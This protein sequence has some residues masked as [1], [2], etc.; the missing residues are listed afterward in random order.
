MRKSLKQYDSGEDMPLKSV[1]TSLRRRKSLMCLL[2]IAE[3][4]SAK[5][6]QIVG[7]IIVPQGYI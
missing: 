5:C 6:R 1:K 3:F 7:A 2:V 4:A